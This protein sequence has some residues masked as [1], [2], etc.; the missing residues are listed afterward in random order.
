MNR[1]SRLRAMD[2]VLR[3]VAGS[4]L[5]DELVLRGSTA[6]TAYVGA[7]AREPRDIDWIVRR[8]SLLP[9]DE[10]DPYPYLDNLDAVQTAPEVAHGAGRPRMW[11]LE[12]FDT[13]GS[14]PR[15]PE[16]GMHWMRPD[17]EDTEDHPHTRL[18]ELLRAEPETDGV[19]LTVD[20][21]QT[22]MSADY[23][24]TD[25]R[26]GPV[27]GHDAL[28]GLVRVDVP[29]RDKDGTEGPVQID[30]AYDEELPEPPVL[31]AVPIGVPPEQV[32]L[33]A[34]SASLSLM[35]KLQWLASDQATQGFS[36]A[37]DLVDAVLLA[38]GADV[39]MPVSL[40]RLLDS[41]LPVPLAP[42]TI[43]TWQIDASEALEGSADRWLARLA[44]AV[45][46][47]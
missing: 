24:T 41:R 30:F 10:L 20:E 33:W 4:P 13:Y 35:W 6:M 1:S 40:R 16:E 43:V 25:Y 28:A 42:E 47:Q 5:V 19:R 39:R 32:A 23:T 11:E 12:E 31:L 7:A 21:A 29:W 34:A 45:R 38:E 9:V 22:I 27:A 18:L 37:K 2:H 17:L 8:P 26:F 14:R 36:S 3:V 46:V 15:L 44:D